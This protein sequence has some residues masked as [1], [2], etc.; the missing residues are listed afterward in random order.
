[1]P[2]CDSHEAI[3]RDPGPSHLRNDV[4]TGHSTASEDHQTDQ[5]ECQEVRKGVC[6]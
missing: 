2:S 4:L 5:S 3:E 1:M 6:V